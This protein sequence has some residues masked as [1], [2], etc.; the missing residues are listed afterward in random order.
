MAALVY[1]LAICAA[2]YLVFVFGPWWS[3]IN[4]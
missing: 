4:S 1:V 3:I 2:N